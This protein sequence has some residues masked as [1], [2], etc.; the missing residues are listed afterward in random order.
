M[1]IARSASIYAGKAPW[2]LTCTHRSS[3]LNF[4]FVATSALP[5][6]NQYR[7]KSSPEIKDRV[8]P[9]VSTLPAPISVLPRKKEQS[10]F[11]YLWGAGKAYL[12]FYKTGIKNILANRRLAA[13]IRHRLNSTQTPQLP[14][15]PND[16]K[17]NS[18]PS[19]KNLSAK[20]VLTR[21]EFQLLRRSQHDMIRVPIF[22]L[23]F[24]ILGE[25]LPLVAVFFTPLLPYTCRVPAQVQSERRVLETRRRRSFRGEIDGNVPAPTVRDGDTEVQRINELSRVQL[26]HISRSLGRHIRLWD[27]TKGTLP[28]AV[29]LKS[30][31]A[32]SLAY[33]DQDDALLIRDGGI[34]QLSDEEVRIACEERGIDVLEKDVKLLRATL[35]RW[36]KS[37]LERTSPLPKLLSRP[38]AWKVKRL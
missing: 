28:P 6:A 4:R 14:P 35:L 31:V 2:L 19:A 25:W 9:P 10:Y 15:S 5:R 26:M 21:A 8:N 32:W 34:E 3:Y 36:I 27:L 22:G 37:R 33:L 18:Q 23:L 12:G 20:Y 16:R 11:S 38:E 29:A 1:P 13:A 30:K 24:I 17:Q 7:N